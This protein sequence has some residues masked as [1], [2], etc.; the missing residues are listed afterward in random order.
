MFPL[1]YTCNYKLKEISHCK[2]SRV[3]GEFCHYSSYIS[4][5]FETIEM[6]KLL[7]QI[8][9]TC[10]SSSWFWCMSERVLL[11]I[12]SAMTKEVLWDACIRQVS[13]FPKPEGS[14]K[15][16]AQY[17]ANQDSCT[18]LWGMVSCF[19]NNRE[20]FVFNLEML[21]HVIIFV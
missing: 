14:N 7:L 4:S 10:S 3:R 16:E 11:R 18:W 17:D 8:G 13:R 1:I 20:M 12:Y 5:I 15:A 21:F 6:E 19:G 9:G 2:S